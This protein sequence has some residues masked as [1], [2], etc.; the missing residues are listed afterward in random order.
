[1]HNAKLSEFCL[2][3]SLEVAKQEEEI[4]S[5]IVIATGNKKGVLGHSLTSKPRN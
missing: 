3:L 5:G 4:A 2:L 1:M